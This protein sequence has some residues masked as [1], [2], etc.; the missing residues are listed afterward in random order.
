LTLGGGIGWIHRKH[1]LACDALRAAEVVTTDGKV[2]RASAQENPDLFWAIRGGGGNFGIVVGFTFEAYP[3]GPMVAAAP[4]FYPAARAPDVM[5]KWRDWASSAP[6][7]VTTRAMF[8]TM[9]AAPALPAP[10][11]N[12]Q[13]F[14]VAAL[15]AGDPEVGAKVLQPVRKFSEPLADISGPM[16]YRFF[17]AAFDPLLTGLRS[18]W[19][20]IYLKELNDAAIDLIA[21]HGIARPDPK[22]LV[23]VPLM[24]GATSRISAADT[25]FGDRSAPWLLSVDGNWTDPAKAKDV[26]T[27]TRALIT[28][29]E[30]LVGAGGT[31]LNFTGDESTDASVIQRQFGGN[32]ERLRMLKKKYDP[33]NRLRVNNNIRPV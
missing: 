17:Q 25:A 30:K 11:H 28:E 31:Y 29:A 10:V 6:D 9:P 16:P 2:V 12:Q 27:W 33:D 21:R 24:G 15:Y 7:E 14:I 18:Y 8:W 3:L 23:H 20:S 32:L 1:G 19:K 26:I 22:V 4:V 5:R 13:V